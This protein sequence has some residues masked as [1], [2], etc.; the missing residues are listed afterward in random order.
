L[1]ERAII[2]SHAVLSISRSLVRPPLATEIQLSAF[3]RLL[4][5][6]DA[7]R[8]V[9]QMRAEPAPVIELLFQHPEGPRSVLRCLAG[10]M[11]LLRKSAAPGQAGATTTL[12]GIESLMHQIKRIDWS[13]QMRISLEQV[14]SGERKGRPLEGIEKVLPELRDSILRIHHLISDGFLSHQAFI[15]ESVQPMLLG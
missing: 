12:N 4:G 1:L 15:A 13:E 14:A 2:T 3:L 10:C 9:Y 8:R 11:E 6:R 5:T 7:Y